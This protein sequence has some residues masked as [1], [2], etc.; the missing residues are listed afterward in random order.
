MYNL[1]RYNFYNLLLCIPCHFLLFL[2]D[3]FRLFVVS[4]A[5]NIYV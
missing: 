2:F 4:I 5:Y 3:R 1:F